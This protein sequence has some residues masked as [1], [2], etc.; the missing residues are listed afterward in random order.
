MKK[1]SIKINV[2]K[3]QHLITKSEELVCN[4]NLNIFLLRT[5]II[6]IKI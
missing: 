2:S 6:Q 3:S 5:G 4:Q 1:V